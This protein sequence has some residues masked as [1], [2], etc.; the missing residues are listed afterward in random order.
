MKSYHYQLTTDLQDT[1]KIQIYSGGEP[2]GYVQRIYS[3]FIKKFFDSSL[4]YKYFVYI[5]SQ[6]DGFNSVYCR[7]IQSKGKIFFSAREEGQEP[8]SIAYTGWRSLIPDLLIA[9]NELQIKLSIDHEDW[10]TY[11]KDDVVIAR[12]KPT[13]N[14]EEQTFSIE[15]QIEDDN[16]IK[17]PSVYVAI[18]QAI[19]F[20]GA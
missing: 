2:V 15:L 19:L 9:N 17:N 7:K 14:E 8:Y 11:S 10:S 1:K 16:P 20:I 4:D 18:S 13:F 5:E 12:W 3:N 6:I